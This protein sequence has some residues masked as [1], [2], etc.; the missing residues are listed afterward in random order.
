MIEEESHYKPYACIYFFLC[1]NCKE[2]KLAQELKVVCQNAQI[3]I[4]IRH[5]CY[6]S[7]NKILTHYYHIQHGAIYILL[8]LISIVFCF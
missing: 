1:L 2:N 7:T 8:T 4:D 3:S 6:H 5:V